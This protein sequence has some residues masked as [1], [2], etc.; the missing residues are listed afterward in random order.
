MFGSIRVID[1]YDGID[2]RM[3]GTDR[4]LEYDVL[5][6]PGARLDA[7]RLRLDGEASV[8]IN[9][10]GDAEIALETRT[11]VQRAPVMYQDIDG[12]RKTVRGSY[13]LL[14]SRTLGF[15]ADPYDASHTLV[16]D[17]IR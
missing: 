14:D 4:L 17:P 2:V 9:K 12:V 11:L 13:V 5:V 8:S 1:A 6:K 3:Y 10:D 15:R 7:F 16:V